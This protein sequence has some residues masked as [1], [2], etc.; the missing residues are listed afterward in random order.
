MNARG[1][2]T[3][4]CRCENPF[5]CRSITCEKDA[6]G[7]GE[8]IGRPVN[9]NPPFERGIEAL[10]GSRN[11]ANIPN[12]NLPATVERTTHFERSSFREG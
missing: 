4:N 6:L 10:M 7:I 1:R 12:A 9:T 8:P 2:S 3:I 5:K 11:E